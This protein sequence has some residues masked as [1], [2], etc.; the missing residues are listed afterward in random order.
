DRQMVHVRAFQS[1]QHAAASQ[2]LLTELSAARLCLLTLATK[3]AYD[4]QL[5]ARLGTAPI[6]AATV[7]ARPVKADHLPFR[8]ATRPARKPARVLPWGIA[9][10]AGAAVLVIAGLIYVNLPSPSGPT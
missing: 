5:R 8:P 7:A 4:A 6:P 2:K 3:A 9:C 10:V 1:G